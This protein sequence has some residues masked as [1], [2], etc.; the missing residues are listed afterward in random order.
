MRLPLK[1]RQACPPMTDDR[2]AFVKALLIHTDK[3][4]A[5]IAAEAGPIN[6]GRVAEIATGKKFQDVPPASWPL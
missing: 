3:N 2:A 1:K 6:Q 4:Y 5:Q